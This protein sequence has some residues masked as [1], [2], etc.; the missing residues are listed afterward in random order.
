MGGLNKGYKSI[1]PTRTL[2]ASDCLFRTLRPQPAKAINFK[3]PF[4][5]FQRALFGLK[6]YFI[7][8]LL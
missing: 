5:D 4:G 8:D 2:I 1:M 3:M 7:V 6:A